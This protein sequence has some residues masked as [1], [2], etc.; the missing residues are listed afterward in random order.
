MG[1]ICPIAVGLAW[2]IKKNGGREKVHAF[3]GDMTAHTGI[4][5]ESRRYCTGHELPVRWIIENNG[6]SV[7]TDTLKAWGEHRT[8]PDIM[9][10]TY[11]MK[12]PH[13]GT[14]TFIRF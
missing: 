10:Y 14:G 11:K 5:Q 13:V 8:F 1:G 9:T 6:K 2:G 7:M 4:F 12:R 3:L